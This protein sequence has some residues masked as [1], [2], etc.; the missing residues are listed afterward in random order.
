MLICYIL[1]FISG[2]LFLAITACV[3]AAGEEIKKE[4]TIPNHTHQEN[5]YDL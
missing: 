1:G 3:F 2:V 4:E 5:N